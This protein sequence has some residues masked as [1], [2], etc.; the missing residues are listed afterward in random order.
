M[1]IA[2]AGPISFIAAPCPSGDSNSE[3]ARRFLAPSKRRRRF[4]RVGNA[5]LRS[6]FLSERSKKQCGTS[7]CREG[8]SALRKA[9]PL[10]SRGAPEGAMSK[11]KMFSV[12]AVAAILA[13][14]SYAQPGRGGGG[15]GHGFGGAGGHGFGG[16]GGMAHGFGGGGM[17][18]G[19]AGGGGGMPSPRFGGGAGPHGFAGGG[20]VGPGLG[21]GGIRGGGPPPGAVGPRMGGMGGRYGG[22]HGLGNSPRFSSRAESSSRFNRTTERSARSAINSQRSRSAARPNFRDQRSVAAQGSGG[23]FARNR[24]E[25]RN[26]RVS[27]NRETNSGRNREAA[28]FSGSRSA[29]L[30][31]A[32]TGGARNAFN[33][34]GI[35]ARRD[36]GALINPSRRTQIVAAAAVAGLQAGRGRGH[37]GWWRHRNGG[38]GWVG[39]L[40]WPFAYYDIYDYTLFGYAD[41][42][43][44]WGYGYGDIYAG[45][46]SPYSYNDLTGYWSKGARRVSTGRTASRRKSGSDELVLSTPGQ[47]ALMCGQDSRDIAGLSVEQVQQTI[48]LDEAQ[49]AALDDLANASLKAAQ[50]ISAACPTEIPP[51]APA[52]LA[53]MQRRIEA[54]ISAVGIVQQPLQKFYDLLNDEQKARLNAMGQDQRRIEAANDQGNS[55]GSAAGSCGVTPMAVTGWPEAEIDAKV[56]LTDAQRTCLSS[57]QDA[58]TQAADMLKASCQPSEAITP[59]ARLE[60]AGKRLDVMLQAVKSVRAALED[61]YGQPSEEQKAQF[62]AIGPRRSASAAPRGSDRSSPHDRRHHASIGGVNRHEW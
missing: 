60:A 50:E 44:F 56:H 30:P 48:Q 52:R 6:M 9:E 43:P 37:D 11:I 13:G 46:F 62:E 49:R 24:N 42:D 36:T 38:Y 17:P 23:R 3:R 28:R 22:A 45:I 14:A 61:F 57:L 33:S 18:H 34:Q 53:A 12:V 55:S 59:P 32:S 31:A 35:G 54:M 26:V 5:G 27:R 25:S 29:A 15:G 8:C 40:F 16:G 20:G 10:D 7:S 1:K 39:P 47:L 4:K 19:F 58:T 41:D 21:H 51:S 2:Q